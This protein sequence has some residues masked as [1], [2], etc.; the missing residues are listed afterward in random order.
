LWHLPLSESIYQP[1]TE[2]AMGFTR[3]WTETIPASRAYT[4]WCPCWMQLVESL[5]APHALTGCD[6]TSKLG[7]KHAE[8][9][10]VS[11]AY[12]R[13]STFG[14]TELTEEIMDDIEALQHH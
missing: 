10:F 8:L 2:G 12:E 13:L 6:T 11:S 3:F 5:P 9:M 4:P 14:K 1:W 7:T